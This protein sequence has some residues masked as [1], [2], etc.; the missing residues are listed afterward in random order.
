MFLVYY[1]FYSSW[2]IFYPTLLSFFLILYMIGVKV[3]LESFVPGRLLGID[4]LGIGHR[5]LT[6]ELYSETPL[7]GTGGSS[8]ELVATARTDPSASTEAAATMSSW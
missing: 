1:G 3:H 6:D 7:A 4:E 5:R 2:A 8:T